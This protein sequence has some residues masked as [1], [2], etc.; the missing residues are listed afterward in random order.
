MT[1]KLALWL[2]SCCCQPG[3]ISNSTCRVGT[4]HPRHSATAL[5]GSSNPS[6]YSFPRH[7]HDSSLA[8][9]AF[10]KPIGV[11]LRRRG[12]SLLLRQVTRP[13]PR[14]PDIRDR[15]RPASRPQLSRSPRRFPHCRLPDLGP[16]AHLQ[17]PTRRLIFANYPSRAAASAIT[18]HALGSPNSTFQQHLRDHLL[19]VSTLHTM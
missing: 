5:L 1:L 2:A 11:F 12:I 9:L 7:V 13:A 8:H 19:S 10:I 4:R 16:R 15:I 18:P 6:C 14:F 3:C 17:H